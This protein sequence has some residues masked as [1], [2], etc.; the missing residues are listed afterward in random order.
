MHEL[1]LPQILRQVIDGLGAAVVLCETMDQSCSCALVAKFIF[2]ICNYVAILKT[3]SCQRV[4]HSIQSNRSEL[5]A[6]YR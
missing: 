6:D 5:Y 2:K 3:L 4:V 1:T